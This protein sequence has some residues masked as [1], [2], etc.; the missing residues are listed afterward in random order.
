MNSE[1]LQGKKIILGVTG[2]IAAYKAA[3][4]IRLL[5]QAGCQVQVL[6]TRNAKRFITPLTL[7]TL[8]DRPVFSRMWMSDAELARTDIA[9]ISLAD[10]ADLMVVAPATA[11]CIG[12]LASGLADDLLSTTLLTVTCPVLLCPAMTTTMYE[13]PIVAENLSKL[14]RHGYQILEPASGE[15]ACGKVGAGRMPEPETILHRIAEILV[16]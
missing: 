3:L 12:K 7:A 14:R 16:P 13:N 2:G 15:L 10:W 5:R 1:N 6:M 4:L 8:S 11:N 9:H